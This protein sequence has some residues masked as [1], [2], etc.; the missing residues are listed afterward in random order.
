[1]RNVVGLCLTLLIVACGPALTSKQAFVPDEFHM[2]RAQA[3]AAYNLRDPNAAQFRNIRGV[4]AKAETGVTANYICGEINGKNAMGGYVGFTPF[5]YF[6][7]TDEAIVANRDLNGVNMF[8][9]ATFNK[10][11]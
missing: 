3:K 4:S 8:D 11:C 6:I 1:M 7:S 9:Q 2:N 10:Y 5:V